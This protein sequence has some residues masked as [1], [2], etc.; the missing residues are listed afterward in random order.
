MRNLIVAK[1]VACQCQVQLLPRRLHRN[2]NVI[3]PLLRCLLENST[4]KQN[5]AETFPNAFLQI[6]VKIGNGETE[7]ELESELELKL[8]FCPAAM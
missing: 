7:S 5:E 2:D 4:H 6:K 1:F 3:F 8:C